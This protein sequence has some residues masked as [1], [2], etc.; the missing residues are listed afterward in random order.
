MI[1][2]SPWNKLWPQKNDEK[3]NNI[4]DENILQIC[5]ALT[6]RKNIEINDMSEWKDIDKLDAGFVFLGGDKL[7]QPVLKKSC[8]DEMTK[9]NRK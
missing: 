1:L 6:A 9:T 8:P 3:Y 4:D 5:E 7:T 2:K